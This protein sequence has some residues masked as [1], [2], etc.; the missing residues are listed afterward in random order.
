MRVYVDA[1]WA[2]CPR[3]RRSTTGVALMHGGHLIRSLSKTQTNIALS[4]AGAELYAIVA[5]AS[6]GLGRQAMARDFGG[7]LK[8]DIFVDASAAIGIAQRKGFGRISHLDTQALWG[9]DAVRQKRVE[10]IKVRGTQTPADMMTKYLD[11]GSLKDMM[12]RLNL[13]IREGRPVIAPHV[14][15]DCQ[16]DI[17]YGMEEEEGGVHS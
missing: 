12:E 6:E 11:A 2:G 4:S 3:T 15:K 16:D 17:N 8:N 10:L 13:Q 14:A 5:A 1:N 7:T 9:Q